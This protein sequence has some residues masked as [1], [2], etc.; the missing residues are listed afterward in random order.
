MQYIYHKEAS[1]NSI[2][3]SCD[4]YKYLF[5]ARREKLGSKI[6]FR[7]LIDSFLYTYEIFDIT[8]KDAT[9]KLV[10]KK[11]SILE[12][13]KKLHLVW[14]VVDNKTIEK[15]LSYLNE[16]GV[17]KIS[18]V[19]CKYSQKNFKLNFDKFE[20][21]LINSSQQCGRSS[22]IKLETLD[23][24]DEVL[25]L[26]PYFFN[27]SNNLIDDYVD[28]IKVIVIGPEGGFCEN[29]LLKVESEKIVGVKSNLILKSETAITAAAVKLLL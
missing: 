28:D 15:Q 11:E 20:K 19:Y 7:N 9:L 16:L 26:N 27:F 29:E 6:N 14:C 24:F 25:K 3:V 17:D 13:N 5:K 4:I 23:S 1:N 10:E 8:K 12:S 21:I 22:I 18:F 2:S